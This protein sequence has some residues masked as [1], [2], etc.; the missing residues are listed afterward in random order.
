MCERLWTLAQE[1]TRP[2][3]RP[4]EIR[5]A[6][7]APLVLQLAVWG[8]TDPQRLRWLEPPPAA[9][10]QQAVDLLRALGALDAAGRATARGQALAAWPLHPRL[11]TMLCAAA[12]SARALAADL[13][14]VLSE[15]DPLSSPATDLGL[16]LGALAAYRRGVLAT[17]AADARRLAHCDRVARQLQQLAARLPV[18]PTGGARGAP[19]LLALAY[20]EWIA[21]RRA[22]QTGRYLLASGSGAVLPAEDALGTAPYLAVAALDGASGEHRIRL[23]LPLEA[24]TVAEIAAARIVTARELVWDEERAAVACRTISRLDALRLD[25]HACPIDDPAAARALLLEQVAARFATALDW[26]EDAR[27]LQARVALLRR[28]E[29]AVGWPDW[30]DDALRATLATWLAPALGTATRL[31]ETRALDLSAV[32]LGALD[33]SLRQRLDEQAPRVFVTPAGTRRRIDYRP[34]AGPVLAVALQ[35]LFGTEETPRI[36][37]GRVP[38]VLHLLSPAR[39]PLQVTSDLASFWRHGY[40]A[41]RKELRGRYPRH[42]WPEDP[43]RAPAVAGPKRRPA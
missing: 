16:R 32:L 33:W 17:C 34:A 37:G 14:A 27:Q 7:L 35:E 18:A 26:N 1:R 15:R 25:V 4:P 5:H 12:P 19:E 22:G 2:D 21:Q 38:L 9:A 23:A 8:V 40:A 13:A 20:P 30:S 10:W 43:R 11:A 39:R 3:Q 36:A 6:D 29:P 28:L 41:V 42:P 24:A 31:A